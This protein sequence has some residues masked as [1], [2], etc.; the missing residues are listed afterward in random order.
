MKKLLLSL[1]LLLSVS[2]LRA[3]ESTASFNVL[4]MPALV[5]S[6]ALGGKNITLIE[7][8][9]A[10]GWQ[11]PALYANV[12]D[13]SLAVN[14]MTYVDGGGWMGAHFTKALGE[15]HTLAAMAQYLTYGE[16]TQTDEAGVEQ[17]TFTPKDIILGV[18]Y[19]YL[20]SERWSGGANAKFLV[21]NLGDYSSVVMAY[22]LGLNYYDEEED[23]SVSA[24]L[25]NVGTQL[26]A[27]EN[28]VRTHLPFDLVFGLS[29]G[30]AHLPVRW[31]VT[32]SDATRWKKSYFARTSVDEGDISFSKMF[33][34]HFG[35]GLDILP[36]DNIY[37]AVGYNCRRGNEL[38]AAGSG[39]MAGLTAGA[40]IHL[41]RLKFD[42][43]YA[44]YHKAANSIAFSAAYTF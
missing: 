14:Y 42:L 15:R 7:D 40:G 32:L 33:L 19:S 16:V 13:L 38:K 3:Q 9:P 29:M 2:G 41:N 11:N 37:L 6:T 36:T 31:H 1:S 21:S 27:Y 30:M 35:L 18:G 10:V 23:L 12:S 8:N 34:N 17:G 24:A 43:A 39:S 26:K 20:L 4:K 25:L 22:D 28:G 5:H 44:R